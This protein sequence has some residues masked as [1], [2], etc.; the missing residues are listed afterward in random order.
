MDENDNDEEIENQQ[1]IKQEKKKTINYLFF[2]VL[3]S[4]LDGISLILTIIFIFT[5]ITVL[6][7][8]CLILTLIFSTLIGITIYFKIKQD[9]FQREEKRRQEEQIRLL[10][11]QKKREEEEEEKRRLKEIEEQK[12][13]E[14]EKEKRRLKEIEEQKKKEE[15][16]R[17]EEESLKEMKRK[18]LENQK[19]LRENNYNN[20]DNNIQDEKQVNK[21]INE[22]LEDMCIYGNIIEKE[23]K[24]EKEKHPEKFIETSQALQLEKEDSGIF[25]LGLIS[26]NLESIGVETAIEKNE[27]EEEKDA[28]SACLQF[29]TNGM[30]EKKKYDLHFD[31]GE[32]RNEELLDSE[33][34]YEKFKNDLK[35]KLSKDYNIPMDKIIV[36]FPQKGSYR[37]QV[38]FQSDEFNNLDTNEFI[39]K[40][41]Y[42]NEFKELSNLKE[43]H[44]DLVMKGCKL[45][46]NQLDPRGNRNDGWGVGECRGGKP[47]NPPIGWNGIGLKVFDK[48]GNNTWLGMN[49]SP[50]EWCVAYHGVGA[51]QAPKDVKKVT[52]LIYNG[53][54][55]KGSGQVHK[56]CNDIH[57]YSKKVGEGVYCTP[58][59]ST[60]E[61]YAGISD[62]NGKNYKTV[63]MVRVKPS[64]IRQCTCEKDYWVVNGTIDEIRPYR[65][66]YKKV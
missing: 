3:F 13:R 50:G 39:N 11:E 33:E 38:I 10:E 19:K 5:S 62:V 32:K 56:N 63:L 64:A 60:A 40:F 24:E 46:R 36:T 47:Y 21:K 20:I 66:L 4:I 37:V 2:I 18:L 52:N 12:K 59:V 15:E 53:S 8:L 65:I 17:K 48:Y 25:A 6:L 1:P 34:E 57:H 23:I 41:K 45:A 54:F 42:D 29:I 61:G 31:F 44:Q 26:Q 51:N 27:N 30:C 28:G 58:N 7:W 9:N 43:I 55:K 49:N 14:E 22:T 16:K 35:L